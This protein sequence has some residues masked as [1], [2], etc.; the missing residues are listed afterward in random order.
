MEQIDNHCG[1]ISRQALQLYFYLD[2]D[3]PSQD[4][5]QDLASHQDSWFAPTVSEVA[6]GT[7]FLS[8]AYGQNTR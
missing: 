5:E 3:L 2:G 7:A 8:H 6:D 4:H 1:K